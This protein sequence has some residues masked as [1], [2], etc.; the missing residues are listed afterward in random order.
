MIKML[1][2]IANGQIIIQN[3]HVVVYLNISLLLEI[4][5][6]SEGKIIL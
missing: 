1:I 4:E 3:T 6:I 5:I 2:A